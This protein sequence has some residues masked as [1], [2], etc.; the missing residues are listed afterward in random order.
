MAKKAQDAA[1][2]A[3]DI[4]AMIAE[5]AYFKSEQRGFAP[6]H[7]TEDW[8]AA[9]AEIR[10]RTKSKTGSKAKKAPRKTKKAEAA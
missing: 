9:E 7:E 2:P 6:G 5:R 8:L 1:A 10:K 3:P 4:A